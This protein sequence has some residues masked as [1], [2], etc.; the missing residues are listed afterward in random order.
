V[1]AEAAQSQHLERLHVVGL[2]QG[3]EA[4]DADRRGA[5]DELI[6][7]LGAKPPTLKVIGNDE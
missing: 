7:D 3:D 2:D 4:A 6:E 5:S 1:Q